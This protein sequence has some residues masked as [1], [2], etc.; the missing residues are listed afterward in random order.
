MPHKLAV[1]TVREDDHPSMADRADWPSGPVLTVDEHGHAE[2]IPGTHQLDVQDLGLF[3]MCLMNAK[4]DWE[5]AF[6]EEE[7]EPDG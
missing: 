4:A 7:E 5:M 2:I 3:A 6:P 1:Y